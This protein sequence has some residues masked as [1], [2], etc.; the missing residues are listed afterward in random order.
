MPDQHK[1]NEPA[2]D[3]RVNLIVLFGGQS[4]EHDVSCV[5]ATHVLRAVDQDRYRITPIAITREG[6][7]ELA[8]DAAWR[9]GEGRRRAARA[10]GSTR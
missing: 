2:P 5:T 7:W 1:P 10:F 8:T 4:A 9:L 3:Q 6:R